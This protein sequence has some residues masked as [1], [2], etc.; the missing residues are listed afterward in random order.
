MDI[1]AQLVGGVGISLIVAA[2]FSMAIATDEFVEYIKKHLVSIIVSK[3][4]LRELNVREKKKML[5]V[6][7]RPSKE[8]SKIYSGIDDYFDEYIES[9]VKLFDTCYRGHLR[10][11]IVASLCPEK[12]LLVS[13][14]DMD[15]EMYRVADKFDPLVAYF[16]DESSE[17]LSTSIKGPDGDPI[18][19]PKDKYIKVNDVDDETMSQGFFCEIPEEL[20]RF[21]HIYVNRTLVEYGSDHW[22]TISYKAIKPCHGMVIKVAC[23]DGI[24]IRN[25]RT[26]GTKKK[27]NI[28]ETPGEAKIVCNDWL[29]PGFG[30]HVLLGLDGFHVSV[31]GEGET[32]KIGDRP[33]F[34]Q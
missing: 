15:Y 31:N 25:I 28:F 19:I 5:D 3:D 16:E 18:D 30:V 2:I 32:S 4:F 17:L 22:Q 21:R 34:P 26:F 20:N 27:F 7:L 10:I 9:S 8:L 1:L 29:S 6:T 13:N 11:D 24:K 14:W 23:K 12:R 33:R